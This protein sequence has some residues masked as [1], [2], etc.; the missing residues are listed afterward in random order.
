MSSRAF[1]VS[2]LAAA[3]TSLVSATLAAED[4]IKD[5]PGAEGL[6][7]PN[8][9]AGYLDLPDTEKHV[10]YWLVESENDPATDPGELLGFRWPSALCP[11]VHS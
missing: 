5:L 11:S 1:V 10:F 9:F 6:T 2:L 3:G 7:L 4:L 8:M